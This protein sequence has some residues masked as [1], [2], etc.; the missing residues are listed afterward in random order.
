MNLK[1]FLN[2]EASGRDMDKLVSFLERVKEGRISQQGMLSAGFNLRNPAGNNESRITE[3]IGTFL[4]I[5]ISEEDFRN[6][7]KEAGF[8]SASDV[9]ST[10]NKTE[11]AEAQERTEKTRREGTKKQ[12][13]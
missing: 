7:L 11:T 8:R 9:A 1:E 10:W 3:T 6:A 4:N 2:E 13:F 12:R 5:K